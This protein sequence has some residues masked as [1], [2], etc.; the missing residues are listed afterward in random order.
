[1]DPV[2]RARSASRRLAA[3]VDMMAQAVARRAPELVGE[4]LDIDALLGQV[5]LNMLLDRVDV[6]RV[7]DRV[8]VARI[9]SRVDMDALLSRVD[10]NAIAD[11]ID[12]SALL[13]KTELSAILS[14][15]SS[16][17]FS[18]GI[19]L[20]RSQ[21][22]GLDNFIARWVNRVLGRG[23]RRRPASAGLR[24]H[25]AGSV[26]R[27]LGYAIDIG[28]ISGLFGLALA[29][30]SF[31]VG[32]VTGHAFSWNRSGLPVAVGYGCWWFAYFAYA[33][34]ASGKTFGM[35]VLGIRVVSRQ[36]GLAGT[37]RAIARTLAFPLSFLLFG[38]GF[39]G[40]LLGGERRA[41]HDVIAGTAVVYTWDARAQ[42]LRFLARG[43]LAPVP[44]QPVPPQPGPPLGERS[45][46]HRQQQ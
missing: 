10:V 26:S 22:V 18:E 20:V 42:R 7:L 12:V 41:L 38:L 32:L 23:A 36:G 27:F 13:D 3:P 40:I 37:R 1:M 4:S 9:I 6:N 44:P 33:W 8:D 15:S 29:A 28:A 2:E 14:R 34:A 30:V 25:Y 43:D 17:V 35:A 45:V 5:D 24:G 46:T 19:D 21:A 11:R 31:A 16:T 39:A